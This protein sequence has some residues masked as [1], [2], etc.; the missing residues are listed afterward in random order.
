M[1]TNRTG[2]EE[3][4]KERKESKRERDRERERERKIG[5]EMEKKSQREKD[6]PLIRYS[7]MSRP[8]VHQ[9]LIVE[10]FSFRNCLVYR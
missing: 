4:E 3:R 9:S 1:K 8:C 7:H 2:K 10:K 6:A 5:R